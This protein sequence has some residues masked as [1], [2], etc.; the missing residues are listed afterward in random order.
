MKEKATP[1]AETAQQKEL[2]NLIEGREFFIF[3]EIDKITQGS[4]MLYLVKR[5]ARAE[6]VLDY[7]E[8]NKRADW[9]TDVCNYLWD[10]WKEARGGRT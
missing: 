2:N 1:A 4:K 8:G 9:D 5:L 10:R 6:A 7:A 3:K